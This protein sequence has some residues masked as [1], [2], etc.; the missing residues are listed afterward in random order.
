MPVV[1]LLHARRD[2]VRGLVPSSGR[3]RWGRT[4]RD[5]GAWL[6][7]VLRMLLL[8][9]LV[10]LLQLFPL[11]RRPAR[12]LLNPIHLHFGDLTVAPHTQR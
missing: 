10:L 4:F 11:G 7:R 1:W 2:T 8:L 6:V 12:L 3:G 9:L 5:D